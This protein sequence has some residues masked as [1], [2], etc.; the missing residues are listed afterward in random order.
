MCNTLGITSVIVTC[1]SIMRTI[2]GNDYSAH[3]IRIPVTR[4]NNRVFL[5]A[6]AISHTVPIPLDSRVP[7]GKA[8]PGLNVTCSKRS[9]CQEIG[10]R[11]YMEWFFALFCHSKM[12][13]TSCP[14]FDVVQNREN[15]L[16]SVVY[17][18]FSSIP[19]Q[20]HLVLGIL[21]SHLTSYCSPDWRARLANEMPKKVGAQANAIIGKECVGA[22]MRAES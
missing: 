15:S 1:H 22:I 3:I 18:H 21:F 10:S 17:V 9:V 14:E 13:A 4:C 5:I 20:L 8:M 16:S 19:L 6:S 2:W 7:N 12:W 11:R